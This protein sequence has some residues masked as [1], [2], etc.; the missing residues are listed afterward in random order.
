MIGCIRSL[1]IDGV[2]FDL[3]NS[4]PINGNL[5]RGCLNHCDHTRCENGAECVEDF[6]EQKYACVCRNE[7]VQSGDHCQNG[8]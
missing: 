5:L 4:L 1:I 8:K 3:M 2:P 6:A 7:W